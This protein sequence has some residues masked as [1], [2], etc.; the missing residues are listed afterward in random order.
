[1][2]ALIRFLTK[3]HFFILFIFLEIISLSLVVQSNRA[4][5][6]R[7]QRISNA[8]SGYIFEKSNQITDYLKLKDVNRQLIE[9]NAQIHNRNKNLYYSYEK[10]IIIVNDTLRIEGEDTT[11]IIQ[12]YSYMP[13]TV[14]NNSVNKRHNFITINRGRKHGV[15][16]NMAVVSGQGVVGIVKDVSNNFALAF[17]ILNVGINVSAKVKKN[18]QIGVLKWQGVDY[19]EATLDDILSHI[20]LSTGDTIVTSGFSSIFP[21]GIVIGTVSM[22]DRSKNQLCADVKVKLATDFKTL[23]YVYIIGNYFKKE[24]ELLEQQ[25][26]EDDR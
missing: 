13:A 19:R 1:M 10:K 3:Y 16:A 12:Q 8:I 5:A 11:L 21:E 22:Y 17:S 23:N 20:D 24:Q 9:E 2:K 18:G 26:V 14:V 7:V 6:I 25:I 4:K 15:E